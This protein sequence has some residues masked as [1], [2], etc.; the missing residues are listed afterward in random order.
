MT[1][2]QDVSELSLYLNQNSSNKSSTS[3]YKTAEKLDFPHSNP[4]TLYWSVVVLR[5][6]AAHIS[7]SSATFLSQL[8]CW[9]FVTIWCKVVIH[10]NTVLL[11][12]KPRA[13]IPL[14]HANT[15]LLPLFPCHLLLL[16]SAVNAERRSTVSQ[17]RCWLNICR[18]ITMT[19]TEPLPPQKQTN[20]CPLANVIDLPLLCP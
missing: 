1:C 12:K 18:F 7:L 19:S 20:L 16:Y 10:L 9:F 11:N 15:S 13:R 4:L 6:D 3:Q 2:I 14:F 5:V 8:V 17:H